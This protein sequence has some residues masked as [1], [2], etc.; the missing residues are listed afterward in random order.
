MSGLTETFIRE[1][2]L[3]DTSAGLSASGGGGGTGQVTVDD[4]ALFT[5]RFSR[6][7]LGIF[8]ATRFATGRKNA[9]R[10]EV[11]GSAGSLA[12]DFESMNELAFYDGTEDARTAG[13]RRILVTEPTHPYAAAWWPAGHGLGYEH[14]FIHE[15][16]DLVRD[17]YEGRE[18]RPSF[19]DGLQVQ[20]VLAAVEGSAADDSR[21]MPV[22]SGS[23]ASIVE[24]A[25]PATRSQT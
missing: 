6:G 19:A 3:P 14:S 24:P 12:F 22:D 7:A 18:P 4:A 10:I 5:A 13:F 2:P 20:R 1:R 8:E 21:W 17:I 9:L 11:N 16:V 25:V 23:N 15:I